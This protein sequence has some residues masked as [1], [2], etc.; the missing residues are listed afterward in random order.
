[1]AIDPGSHSTESA[2]GTMVCPKCGHVQEQRPDCLKCGIVFSKYY[3]LFP[4]RKSPDDADS[5]E[6]PD[7]QSLPEQDSRMLIADLQRQVREISIRFTELEFEKAERIQIRTDLKNME[8][9]LQSDAER[10]IARL[11]QCEK[12]LEQASGSKSQHEREVLL[13][14]LLTRLERLEDRLGSLDHISRQIN[15]L[16]DKNEDFLQQIAELQSQLT[17]LRDEVTETKRQAEEADQ[18]REIDG[19]RTP[20]EDDVHAIRKYLD[21]FRRILSQQPTR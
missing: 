21:E 6:S 14:S 18:G 3:A 4:D 17:I 19:S 11:E 8:Q 2:A 15:S 7:S 12:R 20:L 5:A 10:V 13:P 16:E 1:V 9:Q